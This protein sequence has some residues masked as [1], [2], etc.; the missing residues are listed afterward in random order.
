MPFFRYKAFDSAG[1]EVSGIKEAVSPSVV[2]RMLEEEGLVIFHIE[3]VSSSEKKKVF[4]F[5]L[6]TG[7]SSEEIALI[8]YEIG[9]LLSRGV[10]ITQIFE[11]LSKQTENPKL[12]NALLSIKSYLQ[13]GD[14][15]AQALAK[16]K[17]FPDFLVEMAKA[18]EEAG[19]LDRIFLSASEYISQQN[20]F[21]S[22]I[23]NSLIYPTIVIAVGFVAV[24]II[25][26]LVVPTITKIYSQFG[27]ELPLSTQIVVFLSQ[28]SGYLMKGL[29]AVLIVLFLVRKKLFPP[30]VLDRFKLKIPFFSKVYL[31]SAYSNWSNTL[32]L[33]LKGGITLDKAL[34]IANKTISN[35]VLR[36]EFNHLIEQVKEGK[37]L[38][39]EVK[40]RKLLP[41][42]AVQLI[43]IGEETGQ[44]DDM[45]KLVSEI[46]KK[47]TE[48][49]INIFL[50]YLEPVTLIV[51]SVLI[52]FFVFAT[53]L[54]IFSLNVR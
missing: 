40:S 19:A 7:V 18:G 54:P 21:R 37:P 30:E 13:E 43:S 31:Y 51:L 47:Q 25:M 9:L 44:L 34:E 38:S 53:L 41:E 49:L 36:K 39:I 48:R 5:K 24:V 16:T 11:I 3:E 14:S 42:N 17:I 45:L 50:S 29:P 10:H 1:K 46:Y 12:Q 23:V 52:G 4:S 6:G 8:L 2:K 32:S 28:I 33:L 27:R 20:Q 22:K 26:N 15:V 35:S